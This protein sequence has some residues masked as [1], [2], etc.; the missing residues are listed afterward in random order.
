MFQRCPCL[1]QLDDAVGIQV[2]CGLSAHTGYREFIVRRWKVCCGARPHLDVIQLKHDV[3]LL[4]GQMQ[5]GG[6]VQRPATIGVLEEE[7]GPQLA[8]CGAQEAGLLH[9]LI[10]LRM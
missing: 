8:Q 1:T 2:L 3:G 4:I 7:E 10:H 9:A 5:R 6:V